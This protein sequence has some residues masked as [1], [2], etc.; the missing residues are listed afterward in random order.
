MHDKETFRRK[1]PNSNQTVF[2]CYIL[3]TNIYTNQRVVHL[4][5][6]DDLQLILE[7]VTSYRESKLRENTDKYI[8][9]RAVRWKW[10]TILISAINNILQF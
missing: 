6:I 8:Q 2:L 3:L 4:L 10:K 5:S 9:S 7:A 1:L